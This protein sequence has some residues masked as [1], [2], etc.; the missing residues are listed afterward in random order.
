VKPF[1]AR[2]RAA[3]GLD[4]NV[5]DVLPAG[6]SLQLLGRSADGQ[7]YYVRVLPLQ[8]DEKEGWMAAEVIATFV[9]PD[10][11]PVVEGKGQS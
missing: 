11:L 1:K 6:T 5:I 3:P 9:D 8:G 2:L 4:A 10:T 7:W